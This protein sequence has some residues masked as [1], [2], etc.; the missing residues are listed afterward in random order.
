M[1]TYPNDRLELYGTIYLVISILGAITFLLLAVN[2]WSAARNELFSESVRAMQNTLGWTYI[3]VAA[4]LVFSGFLLRAV[5][6][7]M[8]D[9]H[10]ATLRVN[11]SIEDLAK[12]LSP[13]Q[14]GPSVQRP[15]F[16]RSSPPRGRSGPHIVEKAW[17][18][19]ECSEC[20]RNLPASA[21]PHEKCPHC[22]VVF[23]S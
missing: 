11:R 7:W 20:Y 13:A 22:G 8:S 19:T 1:N 15:K 23:N 9:V 6:Q 2:E 4:G 3:G 18:G 17:G 21:D 5:L 10:L 14:P 16:T 12:L